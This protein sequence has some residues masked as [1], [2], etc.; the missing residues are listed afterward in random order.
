MGYPIPI[1]PTSTQ[2]WSRCPTLWRLEDVE[3]WRLPGDQFSL[4]RNMGS[5][6]HTGM[7]TWWKG[8]TEAESCRAAWEQSYNEWPEVT[9]VSREGITELLS[10][11]IL[12]TI[13]WC[14]VEMAGAKVLMVEQ[15]LGEDGKDTT[16]D[17]VTEENEIVVVTDWK[18]SHHVDPANVHYRL[19]GSDR[20]HQFKHYTWRVGEY[21]NRPVRLF[22][23]V[24]IVGLPKV[25]VKES[26]FV[27]DEQA[28]AEWLRQSRRKWHEMAR[29]K[30][31]PLMVY[32][33]EEGCK[34]FGDKWPCPMWEAC[35][36][37]HGDQEM[38]T[39]F[40]VKEPK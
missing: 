25:I 27:P 31:D 5:W 2:K 34:P 40:Y 1:R 28:Q 32:R 3:G 24:V 16:P 14:R 20:I 9:E 38:M 13:K 37:C 29:M 23:K 36:T 33:R 4:E 30:V 26:T 10:A 11:V 22:R 6:V 21:L 15:P 7:A 35:W 12:K 19:E 8:G 39:K 18:Y 17:L